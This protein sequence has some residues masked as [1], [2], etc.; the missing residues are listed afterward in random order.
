ML[1]P[2]FLHERG[3]EHA[4]GKHAPENR[5]ELLVETADAHVLE[6]EVGR[7]DRIR[8]G[9]PRTRLDHDLRLRVF[10]ERHVRLLHYDPEVRPAATIGLV[11]GTENVPTPMALLRKELEHAD[12]L[13]DAPEVLPMIVE[14]EGLSDGEDDAVELADE[15]SAH[16]VDGKHLRDVEVPLQEADLK[17]ERLHE[18]RCGGVRQRGEGHDGHRIAG[19]D[20]LAL[21]CAHAYS[22]S[23]KTAS[24]IMS[25]DALRFTPR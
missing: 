25:G 2:K 8:R 17:R 21:H 5:A 10:H 16:V 4:R 23:R 18:W 3:R 7:Y 1:D 12:T 9:L 20:P 6:L 22:T 15:R 24:V 14:N 19:A 13:D 11:G